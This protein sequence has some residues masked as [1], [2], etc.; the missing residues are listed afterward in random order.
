[1]EQAIEIEVFKTSVTTCEE[2]NR[3]K[4][5][6]MTRFPG[7]KLNFD[8]EDCDNILRVELNEELQKEH[9]VRIVANAGHTIATLE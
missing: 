7:L 1:M 8:L 5:I 9:I 4:T 3:I 6:L 2:A